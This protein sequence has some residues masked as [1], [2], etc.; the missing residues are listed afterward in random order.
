MSQENHPTLPTERFESKDFVERFYRQPQIEENSANLVTESTQETEVALYECNLCKR[1]YKRQGD[2]INHNERVHNYF[3]F[4]C[5][6][7]KRNLQ[8]S[9]SNMIVHFKSHENQILNEHFYEKEVDNPLFTLY[10]KNFGDR[11]PLTVFE[12]QNLTDITEIVRIN[13]LLKK[14]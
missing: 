6:V 3:N 1:K 2:L 10:T 5:S 7:C 4:V 8:M 14:D 13:A 9:Q 11:W 12:D